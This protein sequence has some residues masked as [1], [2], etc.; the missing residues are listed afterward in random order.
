[1]IGT[2]V[3][4]EGERLGNVKP[5]GCQTMGIRKIA[6]RGHVREIEEES[7]LTRLR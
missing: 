3:K 5:R 7:L 6:D 2:V 1:M 4:G